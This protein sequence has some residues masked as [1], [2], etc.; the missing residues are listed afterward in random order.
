MSAMRVLINTMKKV[1]VK[2]RKIMSG[3]YCQLCETKIT[4]AEAF[5]SLPP[6]RPEDVRKV[7]FD[8][9]VKEASKYLESQGKS[10]SKILLVKPKEGKDNESV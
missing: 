1:T 3:K 2:V 8:C 7:C 5:V 9:A 4:F 10:L 6:H